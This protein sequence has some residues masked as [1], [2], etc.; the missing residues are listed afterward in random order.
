MVKILLVPLAILLIG[1]GAAAAKDVP[2]P[3]KRGAIGSRPVVPHV[4]GGDLRQLP[5]ARDWRPGDP[6]KDLARRRTGPGHQNPGVEKAAGPPEAFH[7]D[8]LVQL[9]VGHEGRL[10]DPGFG[11]PLL[12]TSGQGFTGG[13]PPD[14]SGDVGGNHFIQAVNDSL[15]NGR[16]VVYDKTTGAVLA[17]PIALQ[18]LGAGNCA[19]GLGDTIV[20]YDKMAERWLLAEVSAVATSLCVYVSQTSDPIAGGWFAYEFATPSFPDYAKYAVW[21]DAYYVGANESAPSLIALDRAKM[22]A[23]LPATTQRFTAADLSAFG[24]Q[25]LAPV[26]HDGTRPPPA[27]SPGLFIRHNDDEA[28]STPDVALQDS[29]QLFEFHVDWTTPANSTLTGPI[30]IPMAEISSDF[31]GFTSFSC[32][33]QPGAADLDP[34]RE[35]VMNKPT[36]RNRRGTQIVVGSLLTNVNTNPAVNVNAGVRW[37][38]LR[39]TIAGYGLHQ[40]GTIASTPCAGI[41]DYPQRFMS[42]AAMDAA[43]GIAA[44]YNYVS[45]TTSHPGLRYTGRLASDPAG[46][47]P[48][49][50]QVLATGVASNNSFLYGA[51]NQLTLDDGD[52]CTFFYTGEWNPAPSWGTKIASFRFQ[53]CATGGPIFSSGFESGNTGGWS[54]T[55]P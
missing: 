25:L 1:S 33:P 53:E 52:G 40:Q 47:M 36:Y 42:S 31:C 24:F 8:P 37:F 6:V 28:H 16:F 9:Q 30:S 34:L 2:L 41:C 39:K 19:S 55:V 13:S 5:L 22:L 26:D 27:G 4:F 50:E 46:T 29:L 43:G 11:T 15:G 49:G 12:N 48:Q 54:L 21:S 10:T 20:L 38:E 18:S 35:V 32:I 3:V 7:F 14:T 45:D 17:G 23:G 51:Y 44:A